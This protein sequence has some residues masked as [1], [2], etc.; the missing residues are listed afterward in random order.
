MIETMIET[1]LPSRVVVVGDGA[2]LPVRRAMA[3]MRAP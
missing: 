3:G 2:G 1:A